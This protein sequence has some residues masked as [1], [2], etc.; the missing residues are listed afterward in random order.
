[1]A[2]VMFESWLHKRR[3]RWPIWVACVL[4]V[5]TGLGVLS[6]YDGTYRVVT[7]KGFATVRRGMSS[8]QVKDTLGGPIA[9]ER[10]AEGLECFQYGKPTLKAPEFT[11]YSACYQDG[12][13]KHFSSKQYAASKI[14]PAELPTPA[15]A[16][17]PTQAPAAV[18]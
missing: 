13:L 7:P 2:E 8:A 11:L 16:P 14:D 6:M 10:G 3:S 12:H 1:M 15:P 5:S 9:T 4:L 17:A 18:P